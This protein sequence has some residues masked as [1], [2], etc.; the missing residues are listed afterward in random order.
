LKFDLLYCEDLKLS[1]ILR[2]YLQWTFENNGSGWTIKSA[3]SG[4]Y[5]GIEGDADDGTP[6]IAVDNPYVWDIWPDERDNSHFRCVT[7]LLLPYSRI[8]C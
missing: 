2:S 6:L 7:V 5:I 1:G 3:G 8:M 4:K